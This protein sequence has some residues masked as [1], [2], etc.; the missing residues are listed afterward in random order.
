MSFILK[1]PQEVGFELAERAKGLRLVMNL[2][3]E[4]L[5]R[6]AGL[7]TGTI[8]RF[9]KTGQISLVSFLQIA[10]VLKALDEFDQLFK[11]KTIVPASIEDL[12][13]EPYKPQRGRLK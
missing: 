10:L 6:R 7:S 8:K 3:Q 2:S 13:K 5:A 11:Q 4:G 1:T 12:M 9:E